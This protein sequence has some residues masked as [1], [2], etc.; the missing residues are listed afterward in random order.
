M[1]NNTFQNKLRHWIPKEFM[2]LLVS[3]EIGEKFFNIT[4]HNIKTKIKWLKTL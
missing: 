1:L 2:H 3:N 4:K